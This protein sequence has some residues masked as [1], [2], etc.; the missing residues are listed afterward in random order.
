KI[1]RTIMHLFTCDRFAVPIFKLIQLHRYYLGSLCSQ[2]KDQI[3]RARLLSHPTAGDCI[4]NP[5]HTIFSI[6]LINSVSRPVLMGLVLFLFR[7]CLEAVWQDSPFGE[8][9]TSAFST[10]GWGG[11]NC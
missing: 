11:N 3:C 2:P 4:S 8:S 5:N 9:A 7:M 1:P 10:I 6:Q